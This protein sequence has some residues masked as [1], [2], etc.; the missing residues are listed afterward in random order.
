MSKE[1]LSDSVYEAAVTLQLNRI[2]GS[3]QELLTIWD[4]FKFQKLNT[5]SELYAL[6]HEPQIMYDEAVKELT[7]LPAGLSEAAA[8]E[9]QAGLSL[10]DPDRLYEAAALVR[11]SAYVSR[12]LSLFSISKGRAALTKASEAIIKEKS[13]FADNQLQEK[14]YTELSGLV[15]TFNRVN[16]YLGGRLLTQDGRLSPLVKPPARD[17][18]T[19]PVTVEPE[20]LKQLFETLK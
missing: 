4:S 13:V 12:E 16:D 7:T 6:I 20:A 2:L 19:G 15:D 17:G 11:R 3:V 10:P 8:A 1:I 14:A 5:A 9:Y 18:M